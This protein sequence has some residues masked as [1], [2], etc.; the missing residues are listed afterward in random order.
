MNKLVKLFAIA[1][2]VLSLNTVSAQSTAQFGHIESN[3]L[4]SLMP[5]MKTAQDVL[6]KDA[7]EFDTQMKSMQAEAQKLYDAFQKGEKTMSEL[8]KE[9]KVKEIQDAQSRIQSFQQYAQKALQQK[10]ED[11]MKPIIEKANAAIKLVGEE[12]GLIYIFDLSAGNILYHSNKSLDILPFVK[13][14]LGMQ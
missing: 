3:K 6:K 9:T 8:I 5:E 11:S 7:A 1:L 10:K 12:K 4:M 14:K 13:K 2:C